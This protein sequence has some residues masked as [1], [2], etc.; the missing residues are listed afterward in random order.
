VTDDDRKKQAAVLA[1]IAKLPEGT[2]I[3][4]WNRQRF[5]AN[6]IVPDKQKLN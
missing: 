4:E 5:G 1:S 3:E 6:I 2:T